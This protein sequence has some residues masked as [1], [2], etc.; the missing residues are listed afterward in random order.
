MKGG[1]RPG[2]GRPRGD[3]QATAVGYRPRARDIVRADMRGLTISQLIDEALD[4]TALAEDHDPNAAPLA[5]IH[6]AL[7]RR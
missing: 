6:R 1:K 5:T 4:A 2:A 3:R 7:A